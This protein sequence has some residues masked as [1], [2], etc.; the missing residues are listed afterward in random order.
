LSASYVKTIQ[1]YFFNSKFNNFVT[2]YILPTIILIVKYYLLGV[3]LKIAKLT[4]QEGIMRIFFHIDVNSAFLSWTALELLE[5]G[6]E[7]DIRT[8]PSIVGGDTQTR[9]GTVLAQF[10]PAI[11][12]GI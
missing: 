2:L 6:S 8:I 4:E 5:Q 9:H 10:I 1:I 3:L 12:Y 7:Q 11:A